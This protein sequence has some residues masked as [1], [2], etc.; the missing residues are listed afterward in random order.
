[1]GKNLRVEIWQ[2]GKWNVND[3]QTSRVGRR[4]PPTP[5]QI[6]E[7]WLR[8]LVIQERALSFYADAMAW[9]LVADG[10]RRAAAAR[11]LVGELL[12]GVGTEIG[13]GG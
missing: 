12:A 13:E 2:R 9:E 5:T 4:P 1:V 3:A 8:A 7:A 10:G 11:L 6:S